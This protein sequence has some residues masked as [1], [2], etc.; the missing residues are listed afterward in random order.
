[1]TDQLGKERAANHPTRSRDKDVHVAPGAPSG[2]LLPDERVA[3]VGAFKTPGLSDDDALSLWRAYG[4]SG[5][6]A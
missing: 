5:K 6:A 2:P 4:V 3:V 1:M